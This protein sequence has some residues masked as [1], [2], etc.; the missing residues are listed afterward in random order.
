MTRAHVKL[1]N[2]SIVKFHLWLKVVNHTESIFL[3]RI[4][5]MTK[6]SQVTKAEATANKKQKTLTSP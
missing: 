5:Q 1:S 2:L 6:R 3:S 4:Q